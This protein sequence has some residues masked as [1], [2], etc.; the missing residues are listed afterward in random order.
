MSVYRTPPDYE[1]T[2]V[3]SALQGLFTCKPQTLPVEMIT[4]PFYGQFLLKSTR[5]YR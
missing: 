5:N 4:H 2:A 1:V 3:Q